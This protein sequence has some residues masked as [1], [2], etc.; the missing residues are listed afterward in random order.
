M[1]NYRVV[2]LAVVVWCGACGPGNSANTVKMGNITAEGQGSEVRLPEIKQTSDGKGG[3]P[4]DGAGSGNKV[5]VGVTGKQ[6]AK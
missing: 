1:Q 2:L 6:P 3:N 4:A 5:N